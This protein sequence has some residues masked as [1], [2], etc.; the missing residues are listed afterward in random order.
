MSSQITSPNTEAA[1]LSRVIQV[2]ESRVVGIHCN[3]FKGPNVA[4]V[5]PDTKEIV[6]L[7]HPRLDVW[8]E[9]FRWDG[10]QLTGRTRVGRVTIALLAI[11]DSEFVD[12]RRAL[13]ILL[14]LSAV[15]AH[16]MIFTFPLLLQRGCSSTYFN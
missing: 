11:N 12:V 9:H 4:G 6:R 3:R 15:L 13:F 10:P 5:D 16:P 2:G 1:I 14:E 7:F 8:S